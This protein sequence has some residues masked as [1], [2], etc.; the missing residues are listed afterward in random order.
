MPATVRRRPSPALRQRL[1]GLVAASL[2]PALAGCLGTVSIGTGGAGVS[3]GGGGVG[4]H[5]GTRGVSVAIG[6]GA[7]GGTSR[8]APAPAPGRAGPL[9]RKPV[10]AGRLTSRFGERRGASRRH[11]GVDYAAPSGTAVYA[12]GA[13][14]VEKAGASPS[15]GYHVRIAHGGGTVTTYAHLSRFASGVRAG[16]R[17]RR[18]Q[19]IGAVGSTGR[20][21][22][23]HLHYELEIDG[24]KVDPLGVSP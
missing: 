23:P 4:V 1:A 11:L 18:G 22:S 14:T 10:A 7:G 2:L 21:T 20:S 13:G 16:T 6:G 12:A 19:T 9:L 8:P 5:V 3:L 15:Y 24:V 17:V